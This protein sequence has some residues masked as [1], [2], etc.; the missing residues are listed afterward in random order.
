[1]SEFKV[2]VITFY[3]LIEYFEDIGKSLSSH[4]ISVIDFPLFKYHSDKHDSIR[5]AMS[6]FNQFISTSKPDAIL[7]QCMLLEER[8]LSHMCRL[9]SNILH[10]YFTASDTHIWDDTEMNY[11]SKQVFM[12]RVFTTCEHALPRY[13]GRGRLVNPCVNTKFFSPVEDARYTCDVVFV[14]GNLRH[15]YSDSKTSRLKLL[16]A[17]CSVTDLEVHIYGPPCIETHFPRNYK[18]FANWNRL[19]MI[20][21]NAKICLNT[22]A[23]GEVNG[24]VGTRA[25]HILASGGLLVSDR[26][27]EMDRI[28]IPNTHYLELPGPGDVVDFV[29]MTIRGIESFNHIRENG[30]RLCQEKFHWGNLADAIKEE[31]VKKRFDYIFYNHIN[32]L[33]PDTFENAWK[34]WCSNGKYRN[35]LT[36]EPTIDPEFDWEGYIRENKINAERYDSE[37]KAWVHYL[38][39]GKRAGMFLVYI[40]GRKRRKIT[41]VSSGTPLHVSTR[42][43]DEFGVPG[44][45]LRL[46][47]LMSDTWFCD[48]DDIYGNLQSIN[49]FFQRHTKA[50]AND[51]LKEVERG[52]LHNISI[53]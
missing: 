29:K 37:L 16:R 28:L 50:N 32:E 7:W 11:R 14:V 39:I 45:V 6:E 3:G 42:N 23:S 35:A 48:I 10:F 31:I 44:D 25:F 15:G 49:D 36:F 13:N 34:H 18:G 5:N 41:K 1:M 9:H 30:R 19:S 46:Y 40:E 27:K 22:N 43:G 33:T 51:V 26:S 4:G 47:T 8:Q 20:F 2:L 24:A 12:N 21:S 52:W 17:L 38:E 53:N